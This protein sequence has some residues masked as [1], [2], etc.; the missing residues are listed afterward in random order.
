MSNLI[1]NHDNCISYDGDINLQSRTFLNAL[2]LPSPQ[3]KILIKDCYQLFSSKPIEHCDDEDYS[4][5][6][7][8]FVAGNANPR[9]LAEQLAKS[10]F[11][12]HTKSALFD[13]S[14]SGAEWWVNVIDCNDDVGFHW[15]RDYG[16]EEEDGLHIYPQ[17]GTVTY[18]TDCGG[19]TI[20]L[21]KK[22]T[23]RNDE[24]ISGPITSCLVS[25]PKI[26]KHLCFDGTLLHA[27]PSDLID[28]NIDDNDDEQETSGDNSKAIQKR[29]T[30]LVNI[31]LNHIPTQSTP[32]PDEIVKKLSPPIDTLAIHLDAP[33]I[34]MNLNIHSPSDVAIREWDFTNSDVSHI[35]T[36]PLPVKRPLAEEFKE[37]NTVLLVYEETGVCIQLEK[38]KLSSSSSSEESD[39]DDDNEDDDNEDEE[40]EVETQIQELEM[41]KHVKRSREE[42]EDKHASTSTSTSSTSASKTNTKRKPSSGLQLFANK[43]LALSLF[44]IIVNAYN[45]HQSSALL[46]NA[47]DNEPIALDIERKTKMGNNIAEFDK[48]SLVIFCTSLL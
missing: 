19:P 10:I 34:P 45:N 17:L 23:F 47:I 8:F 46:Y 32:L 28:E 13:P 26:G 20:V 7:T 38:G 4:S 21:D 22:G 1:L 44:L 35:V 15:D 25:Q 37:Q 29:I 6:D 31:W 40:S 2:A 33:V 42:V 24:D 39:E 3:F 16:I 5:G 27:A 11:E 18:L 41:K 48:F 12:C 30:F 36:F 14:I 9:C 43:Y